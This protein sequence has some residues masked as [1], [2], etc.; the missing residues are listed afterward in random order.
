MKT[1]RSRLW[2]LGGFFLLVIILVTLFSSPSSDRNNTGSTFSKAPEGYGAWYAFMEAKGVLISRWQK[3]YLDLINKPN[4]E[5]ITLLRIN[6]NMG[7]APTS[8]RELDWLKK[9]NRLVVIGVNYPVTDAPFNSMLESDGGKI[10]IDTGRRNSQEKQAVLGDNF[11]AVIWKNKIGK[12]EVIYCI[13]QD[14]AA[15]AYQDYPNNYEFLAQLVSRGNHQIFVDEYLHGYKDM[16]TT[17]KETAGNLLE[18]ILKQPLAI[19]LL[20]LGIILIIFF[21]ANLRRFGKP[22]T[23]ESPS[24]DN[25]TAYITALAGV[26][27]QANSNSFVAETI[28]RESQ[29]QLQGKLGL[30]NILLDRQNLINAWIERT[31]KSETELAKL[32]SFNPKN[33]TIDNI[34]LIDW[35]ERWK[36]ILTLPI[37]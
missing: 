31:G 16:E 18:Y 13:S 1:G 34:E 27:Q 22:L 28:A 9:G 6:S 11:G 20:Q 12:G 14:L 7:Y 25:N 23:I 8:D 37:L 19:V 33:M 30:D 17:K 24:I 4:K 10:K 21:L 36:N 2:L 26:L 5:P 35:L 32:L 15:N 29:L 3:P